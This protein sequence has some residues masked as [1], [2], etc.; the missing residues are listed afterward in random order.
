MIKSE[1]CLR[2][3]Y[4]DFYD[5]GNYGLKQIITTLAQKDLNS[6]RDS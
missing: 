1:F 2:R 5:T 6:D 4:I 3:K